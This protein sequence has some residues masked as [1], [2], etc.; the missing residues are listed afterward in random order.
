M[1]GA[2]GSRTLSTFKPSQHGIILDEVTAIRRCNPFPN[3][4]T[5]LRS[6]L[7][8]TNSRIL[9]QLLRVHPGVC[10]NLRQLSFSFG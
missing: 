2:R 5:K 8:K 3:S 6:L 9:K 4:R 1:P 7:N 10:G